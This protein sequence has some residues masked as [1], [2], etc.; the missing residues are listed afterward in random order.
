MKTT[1]ANTPNRTIWWALI[2]V[3]TMLAIGVAVFFALLPVADWRLAG[4]GA[5]IIATLGYLASVWLVVGRMS[6]EDTAAHA[7][8]ED[9][10][11]SISEILVFLAALASIAGVVGLL[12]ARSDADP[13]MQIML[14]G[15]AVA[16]ILCSWMLVHTL[17]MLRYADIHYDH[18]E[19]SVDFPGNAEPRYADFAYLAFTVGMTYQV[20]DTNLSGT[21]LRA[22]ALRHAIIS[23]LMGAIILATVVNVIAGLA[24]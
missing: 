18:T 1:P 17:A 6:P 10:S 16:A 8:R 7:Q 21:H 22:E 20:S 11:G 5:W 24:N 4:A 2:R 12:I 9:P 14:S 3:I 23:F 13:A 19:D 15:S